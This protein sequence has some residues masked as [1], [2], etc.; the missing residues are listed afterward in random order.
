MLLD[1]IIN[2]VELKKFFEK[3]YDILLAFVFGSVAKGRERDESDIDIAILFSK[4]PS[5][6]AS[7]KVKDEISDILKKEVDLAI[8]NDASPILGMQ[9]LKY[10]KLLFERNKGE[11][12]KFFVKTM[13]FYYDLKT[14]RAENEKKILKGRIYG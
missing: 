4:S 1:D 11:Y 13:N 2:S 7:F 9:V 10:G 12:S 3:N 8:L 6:D 5:F 14:C